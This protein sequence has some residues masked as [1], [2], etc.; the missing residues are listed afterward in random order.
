MFPQC[1]DM[2][3]VGRTISSSVKAPGTVPTDAFKDL[4]RHVYSPLPEVRKRW[5]EGIRNISSPIL[6]EGLLGVDGRANDL[7]H[8]NISTKLKLLNE[9]QEKRKHLWARG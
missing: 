6:M 7:G 1:T 9:K 8:S 5:E 2:S 4:H 3:A